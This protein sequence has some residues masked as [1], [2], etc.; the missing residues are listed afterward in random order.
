MKVSYDLLLDI[1]SLVTNNYTKK[2]DLIVDATIKC[3]EY[4]NS[5]DKEKFLKKLNPD[6]SI[7]VQSIF[8]EAEL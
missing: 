1:T 7:L 4:K 5:N 6:L 2:E 3:V 8:K